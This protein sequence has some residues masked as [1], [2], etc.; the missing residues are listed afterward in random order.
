MRYKELAEL[1]RRNRIPD[2]LIALADDFLEQHKETSF[3][4]FDLQSFINASK[5]LSSELI[6]EL[7]D[8]G[9]VQYVAQ[10]ECPQCG[11]VLDVNQHDYQNDIYCTSCGSFV[12]TTKRSIAIYS[13]KPNDRIDIYNLSEFEFYQKRQL[14]YFEHVFESQKWLAFLRFDLSGI[15]L[16]QHDHPEVAIE[17]LRE[18]ADSF[19]PRVFSQFSG[20]G[21]FVKQEGDAFVYIFRSAA[22]AFAYASGIFTE[23]SNL[24][25]RALLRKCRIKA[26][27][28]L[29]RDELRLYLD[30]NNNVDVLGY[31]V[32]KS[33]R[34]EKI[35]EFPPDYSNGV[36][37]ITKEVVDHTDLIIDDI[38][39]IPIKTAV[40]NEKGE[41]DIALEYIVV[42]F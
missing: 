21:L 27:L 3:S 32:S 17:V 1:F 7:I 38:S 18:F 4:V 9:V 5:E 10:I 6:I 15:T 35:A 37:A 13:V 33:Y 14:K 25:E 11:A 20:S 8:I 41:L 31:D 26:F 42:A 2:E 23:Y 36:I 34:F 28:T 16:L 30:L 24:E 39:M 29:I 12:D 19:F 22:Q 40:W